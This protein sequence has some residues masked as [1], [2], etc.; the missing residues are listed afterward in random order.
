MKKASIIL[1]KLK[2]I[3]VSPKII[4]SRMKKKISSIKPRFSVMMDAGSK[5]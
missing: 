4:P 3:S 5:K 2:E 1:C